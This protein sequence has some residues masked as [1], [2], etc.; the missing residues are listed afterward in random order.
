MKQENYN[1]QYY[2]H[3][4][5]ELG[6]PKCCV[7]EF[8]DNLHHDTKIELRQL[9]GS[10]FVPCGVCNFNFSAQD[11]VETINKKRNTKLKP[12]PQFTSQDRDM[13]LLQLKEK[14]A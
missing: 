12:F 6:Y 7:E 11:L 10:G 8:I 13:L 9:Y 5:K 2:T 4:G 1:N 14:T 3:L